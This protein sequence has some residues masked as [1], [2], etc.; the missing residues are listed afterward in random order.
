MATTRPG[1]RCC[2]RPFRTSIETRPFPPSVNAILARPRVGLGHTKT[3]LTGGFAGARPPMKYGSCAHALNAL[4][5]VADVVIRQSAGEPG[6]WKYTNART[7]GNRFSSEL[8]AS[9][10]H[11]AL[12]PPW[13][14]DPVSATMIGLRPA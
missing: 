13:R 5:A 2:T 10:N 4:P 12:L 9:L 7:C 8:R 3:P 1:N 11:C 14:A 6:A